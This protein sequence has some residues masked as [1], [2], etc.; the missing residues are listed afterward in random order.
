MKQE[1]SC[2]VVVFTRTDGELK[3][4]LAHHLGGHY[5]FPKGHVEAGE[6]EEQTALREVYE[7]VHL[8]PTL[9][10]GFRAVCQYDIPNRDVRKQVV[11]F[12]GEFQNQ[13]I[14]FQETELQGAPLVTYGEAM[15]LLTHEE[16]RKILKNAHTFLTARPYYAAYDD[17]YRQIHSQGL[18]W[19]Y[20][21]PTPIVMETMEAFGITPSHKILELGCGEGRD[22]YPLLQ[23]GYSLLATDLSEAAI[24]Y[25]RKKWPEFSDHFA[26]LDCVNGT[27]SQRFDF[28]YAVAVVHMLVEDS[29]RNAFYAFLREHLTLGGLALIC[30][31][32]DGKTERQTNI[33]TAFDLQNRTHEQS[34]KAVQIAST[35]CRMVNFETLHEE[36]KRNGLVVV[37]EGLTSAPPDFPALMYA[38]V[39]L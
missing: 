23:K 10:P 37:K 31:M 19:F 4:V 29:D 9:I 8:R 25:A 22:A 7:E 6:T 34:G 2:G 32:G 28:I 21:D 12:L 17:R 18:Q 33:Q 16:S 36:L 26:V 3:Y 11:F 13:Q 38:I 30:T 5:G 15:A 24:R 1:K 14:R 27:Y 35:S 20:D 39:S